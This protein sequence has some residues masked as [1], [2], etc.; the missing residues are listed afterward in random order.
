MNKESFRENLRRA[1]NAMNKAT[2]S[3]QGA[4]DNNQEAINRLNPNNPLVQYAQGVQDVANL[5]AHPVKTS[6]AVINQTKKEVK[7]TIKKK[8]LKTMKI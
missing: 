1:Q 3:I 4:I 5:V 2:A 8:N 7:E 6:K